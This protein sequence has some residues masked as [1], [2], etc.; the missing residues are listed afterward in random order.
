MDDSLG[1]R[2]SLLLGR[3]RVAIQ[4]SGA[5]FGLLRPA[6]VDISL[7]LALYYTPLMEYKECCA[8]YTP[9]V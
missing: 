7:L 1:K 8:H 6:T 3:V 2:L 5:G 9:G 4:E